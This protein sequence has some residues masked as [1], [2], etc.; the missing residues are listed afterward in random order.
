MSES[1]KKGKKKTNSSS[2]VDEVNMKSVA[3][4]D[5]KATAGSSNADSLVIREL[6]RLYKTSLLPIEKKYIFNKF[7][8]PEILDSELNA[9]PTVLLI[10]QYSTGMA[11]L[12]P[13][14]LSVIFT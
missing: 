13:V 1:A 9:K 5:I 8:H 3:S 4:D 2:A 6:K 10:G 14:V 12:L 7:H 11:F